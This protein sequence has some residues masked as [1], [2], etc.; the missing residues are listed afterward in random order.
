MDIGR[1]ERISDTAKMIKQLGKNIK[2]PVVESIPTAV[3]ISGL[4]STREGSGLMKTVMYIVAGL[5]LLGLILL[6]VDQWITPIFIRRPGGK[7]Y[8]LT[9]GTDL[10]QLNWNTST[11]PTNI[12]VGTVATTS[13]PTT[14]IPLTTNVISGQS[15]YSI[16]MDIYIINDETTNSLAITRY[17]NANSTGIQQR[18]LFYLGTPATGTTGTTTGTTV[19][20]I[21]SAT[22]A[23]AA[24]AAATHKLVVVMDSYVN[25]LY[26]KLFTVESGSLYEE[27]VIIDNVP[28]NKAFRLGIVVSPYALEGYLNGRLVMTRQLRSTTVNPSQGD[29]IYSPSNIVFSPTTDANGSKNTFMLSDGIK[30]MNLRTFGYDVSPSEMVARMYDL[31]ENS[32]IH[33]PRKN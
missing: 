29:I 10:S 6:G 32:V 20:S 22:P 2:K 28:M 17:N 11:P 21:N 3:G 16:T 27:S 18:T 15:T 12:T 4:P 8:I 1:A 23:A 26:V 33:P 24:A 31:V 25:K 7:G 19:G 30:V 9:P 5:L 14:P 13:P